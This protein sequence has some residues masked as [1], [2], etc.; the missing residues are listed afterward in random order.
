MK[1]YLFMKIE[2]Q[3]CWHMLLFVAIYLELSNHYIEDV[4][5]VAQ[6]IYVPQGNLKFLQ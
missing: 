2:L 6:N 5:T 3:N 1:I 4:F